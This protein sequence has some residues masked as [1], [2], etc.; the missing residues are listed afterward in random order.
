LVALA[1]RLGIPAD[2]AVQLVVRYLD[3]TA[4]APSTTPFAGAVDTVKR[5]WLRP[6]SRRRRRSGD[7]RQ[8]TE[9]PSEI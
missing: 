1:Q 8:C 3:H 4:V 6:L 7:L 5:R 9:T 2:D